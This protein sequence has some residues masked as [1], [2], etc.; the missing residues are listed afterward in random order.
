MEFDDEVVFDGTENLLPSTSGARPP[1]AP[2]LSGRGKSK[3]AA[4]E[5]EES[6]RKYSSVGI[7]GGGKRMPGAAKSAAAATA[8]TAAKTA[9]AK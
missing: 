9:P 1:K 3:K 7:L 6:P 4:A 8:A 2:K 5:V